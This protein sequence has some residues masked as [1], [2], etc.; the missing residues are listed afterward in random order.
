MEGLIGT[1]SRG[2]AHCSSKFP[3]L[4]RVF[5]GAG[6]RQNVCMY[7][8]EITVVISR[9][10]LAASRLGTP[11]P[12]SAQAMREV[13]IPLNSLDKA[14]K[15]HPHESLPPAHHFA[16]SHSAKLLHE[17]NVHLSRTADP[18]GTLMPFALEAPASCDHTAATARCL[19]QPPLH[20]YRC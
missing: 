9:T 13:D 10:C 7:V 19:E 5:S 12:C 6:R 2:H 3:A 17:S 15:R 11:T 18:L 4:S 20:I 14:S 8:C 16:H 1:Y